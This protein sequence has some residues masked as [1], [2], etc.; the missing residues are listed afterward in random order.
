M[1]IQKLQSLLPAF[2]KSLLTDIFN[3]YSTLK[4]EQLMEDWSN[5]LIHCGQ[6]A[7]LML[8]LLKSFYDGTKID[9]NQIKFDKF[10]SELINKPKPNPEDA[11]LLLAIPYALKTIYTIRNKKRGAHVKTINPDYIDCVISTTICDWVLSQLLLLKSSSTNPQ[12][13][14]N[15]IKSI[16]SKRIP[17]IEEFEDGSILVLNQKISFKNKLLL[18]LYHVDKRI[19]YDELMDIMSLKQRKKLTDTM[20]DLR[21]QLL[22]HQNSDGVKLSSLG[23]KEVEKIIEKNLSK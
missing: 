11:I 9:S 10:F 19:S 3:E 4:K 22:A 14:S 20:K 16:V 7:E 13:V 12:Q 21:N 15:Y 23:L 1:N 2:D 17:L 18:A 5:C 6:F 8:G